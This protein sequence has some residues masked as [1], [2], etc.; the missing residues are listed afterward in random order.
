VPLSKFL[1]K[2]APDAD[3]V[4]LCVAQIHSSNAC[5]NFLAVSRVFQIDNEVSEQSALVTAEVEMVVLSPFSV[6]SPVASR[7]TGTCW[8]PKTGRPRPGQAS[9]ESFSVSHR[10][11]I[12]KRFAFQKADG[13]GWR[14]GTASLQPVDYGVA[15]S[16]P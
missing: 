2:P 13:G 10:V 3:A 6:C 5:G 8:D 14:C 7:C 12:E 11:R 15:L 9:R 1:G 16:G 4:D